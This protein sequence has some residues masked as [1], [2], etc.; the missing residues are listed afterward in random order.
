MVR[1]RHLPLLGLLSLMA[2]QPVLACSYDGQFNNPFA[3]SYPGA[4]D[5]AIATREAIDAQ[6]ITKPQRLAG[7]KGMARAQWWLTLLNKQW[8]D[9]AAAESYIY[10][11][12][13]Q[14][15]S[16]RQM[17]GLTIHVPPPENAQQV[18]LLSEAALGALINNELSYEQAHEL[19][20]VQTMTP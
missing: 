15:W 11:V 18:M 2:S 6:H 1:S 19:Q 4:L 16:K 12:D 10:L 14:L 8:P 7:S 17:D 9:K 13:S 3:E 20:I 5:I